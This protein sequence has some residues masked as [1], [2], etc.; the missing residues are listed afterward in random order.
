MSKEKRPQTLK[1][2]LR[3]KLWAF[4]MEEP[5]KELVTFQ[6]FS[7]DGRKLTQFLAKA[8]DDT[9]QAAV[10]TSQKRFRNDK[11]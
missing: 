9:F 8:S 10:E 5:P 1:Q 3:S 11:P 7:I 6:S 2:R 4:L